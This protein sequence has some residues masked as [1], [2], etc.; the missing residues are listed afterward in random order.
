MAVREKRAT[1]GNP[2]TT[3]WRAVKGGTSSSWTTGPGASRSLH[4]RPG[5]ALRTQSQIQP[6]RLDTSMQGAAI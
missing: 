5:S 3:F 2:V 6:G 1:I 4:P